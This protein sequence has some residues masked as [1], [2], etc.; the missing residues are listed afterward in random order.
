MKKIKIL[1]LLSVILFAIVI[2]ITVVGL[3]LIW[4]SNFCDSHKNG[5]TMLQYKGV[6][7]IL[8]HSSRYICNITHHPEDYYTWVQLQIGIILC[9]IVSPTLLYI[10]ILFL[11]IIFIFKIKYKNNNFWDAI[12]NCEIINNY[13]IH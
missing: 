6:S 8:G 7:F 2:L 12:E 13:Y 9:I 1:Q 10:T 5:F 3:Y 11:T 4:F